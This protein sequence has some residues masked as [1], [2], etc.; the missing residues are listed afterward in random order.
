[1][2]MFKIVKAPPPKKKEWET[3][4]KDCGF[5]KCVCEDCD[6]RIHTTQYKK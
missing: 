5:F 1:M 4:R 2:N 6:P 3:A